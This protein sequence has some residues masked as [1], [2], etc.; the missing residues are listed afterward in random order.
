MGAGLSPDAMTLAEA[1]RAERAAFAAIGRL[2]AAELDAVKIWIAG[3]CLGPR[4]QPD[5]QARRA[6]DERL[7]EA[8]DAREAAERAAGGHEAAAA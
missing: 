6:L 1:E 7:R 8:L 4:P 3:E 5:A 2:G